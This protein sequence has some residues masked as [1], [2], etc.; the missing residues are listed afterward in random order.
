MIMPII[1]FEGKQIA[2]EKGANLREVLISNKQSPHNGA[3][4]MLNCFGI[5]TCGTCSVKIL[6]K[7][8]RISSKEKARLNF[9]P[10][11]ASAGLR[12]SCRVKVIDNI[13]VQ[14]GKGFW[15][16]EID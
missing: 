16:Q 10:H 15:G 11:K 2:C 14:K 3:S 7:Q 5:G 9:P 13:I 4:A 6:G 8:N 1:E 12:L